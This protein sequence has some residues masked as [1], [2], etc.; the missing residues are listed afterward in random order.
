MLNAYAVVGRILNLRLSGPAIKDPTLGRRRVR[1][2]LRLGV[3]SETIP[4][5][6]LFYRPN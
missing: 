1:G 4:L 3:V 2:I 5:A 6:T